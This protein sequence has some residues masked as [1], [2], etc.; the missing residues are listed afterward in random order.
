M[1]DVDAHAAR[2]VAAI[3][4]AR[5]LEGAAAVL[6]VTPSAVSQRV[7]A[8]ESEIGQPVLHRTR[9]IELTSAGLAVLRYARQLEQLGTELR[10]ELSPTASGPVPLTIVV[11]SDSLHTW[12]LPPLAGLVD[13]VH[14]EVLRED[15]EHSLTLLREGAAVGAVTSEAQPVP[16]C[17]AEQLGVMR[18]LAVCSPVFVER[19]FADGVDPGALST[20]PNVTYDRKDTLQRRCLRRLTRAEVTPPS[21]YIPASAEYAE[22]IRLGMGWGMVPEIECREEVRVRDLVRLADH[23]VV[24]V[25]L[26]WQQWR[27]SS[28]LLR[29]VGDALRGAA[30]AVLRPRTV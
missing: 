13:R 21:H 22:A 25:P 11:N 24:D 3:A 4:E 15:E 9:P 20:A 28:A 1:T 19:W 17:S 7:R 26:Y 23:A 16:G 18:Y 2:T 14:L 27:R 5:T 6:R 10:A 29:E 8:L 12:A 30:R